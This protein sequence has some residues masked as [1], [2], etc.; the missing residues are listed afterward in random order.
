MSNCHS[1][2]PQDFRHESLLM[3]PYRIRKYR[4][5][6]REWVVD[7]FS[8]GVAEYAPITFRHILKLPRTLVL[9]FGGPLAVLLASGSWLLA[10]ATNL[11]LLVLL[12]LFAKYP[13]NEFKV[14]VLQSDMSDITK[15]YLCDHG[16][17]FWVAESEEQVVGMVG[18][19][20]VNDPTLWKQKLQLLH[21]FVDS[22]HR[23]R[24]IAKALVRTVLQFAQ[25]RGYREVVLCTSMLQHSAL[26]L[27][28]S[29]GFQKTALL[30]R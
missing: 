7:L 12:R 16:S 14:L 22:G 19:L 25:D 1:H 9:L 20:P 8:E 17:C 2:G 29:M 5:S 21:L 3:A 13:W 26:A 23:R 15:F 10:L 24:G 11:T 30:I 6:D 28:R 27:Y 4:E 18:A